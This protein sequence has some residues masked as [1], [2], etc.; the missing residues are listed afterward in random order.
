MT[1]D[2][3]EFTRRFLLHVLPGGFHRIRHY[4]L[5]DNPVHR[6]GLAKVRELL[7]FVPEVG[8]RPDDPMVAVPSVFVCWHCGMPMIVIEILE[9]TA[10]IRAPPM[11]RGE[12]RADVRAC[13]FRRS[14]SHVRFAI[15]VAVSPPLPSLR[16]RG[17][18]IPPGRASI[19]T[20]GHP[21]LSI[22]IASKTPTASAHSAVSFIEARST[23]ASN[24]R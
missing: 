2:A 14:S 20:S 13:R 21:G 12:T 19:N 7:D 9:R 5:L 10:P 22:A 17:S 8:I 23:P 18:G 1:R 11:R 16:R 15:P 6:A 24:A 3:H 4:G